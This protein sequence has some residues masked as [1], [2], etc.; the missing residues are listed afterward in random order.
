MAYAYVMLT[1]GKLLDLF[2]VQLV[3]EKKTKKEPKRAGKKGPKVVEKDN[4]EEL[5]ESRIC[6]MCKEEKPNREI[7]QHSYC[8]PCRGI[9]RKW[10]AYDKKREKTEGEDKKQIKEGFIKKLK[11]EYKQ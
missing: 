10:Y 1:A 3:E 4:P 7:G 5:K 2:P 8:K 6:F 11:S 9:Y